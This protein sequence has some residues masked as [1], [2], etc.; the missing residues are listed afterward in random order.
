MKLRVSLCFV[1]LP[2]VLLLG[3]TVGNTPPVDDS[4]AGGGDASMNLEGGNPAGDQG[5][6]QG[7]GPGP[8]DAAARDAGAVD[9]PV[10]RPDAEVVTCKSAGDCAGYVCDLVSGA[11]RTS[12]TADLH[13]DYYHGYR[14][15]PGGACVMPSSCGSDA[16]CGGYDCVNGNCRVSCDHSSHCD[17]SGGYACDPS[18]ACVKAPDCKN[19]DDCKGYTCDTQAGTCNLTCSGWGGANS[20]P[21]AKE[22]ICSGGE[23]LKSTVCQT[24]SECSGY[25]CA[26]G[27]CRLTCSRDDHCDMAGDYR[28][29]PSGACVKALDCKKDEDCKGFVCERGTCRLTC[30]WQSHCAADYVCGPDQTCVKTTSCKDDTDCSGYACLNGTCAAFCGATYSPG[31]VRAVPC[32]ADTSYRCTADQECVQSAACKKDDECN[33]YACDDGYCALTCFGGGFTNSYGC[34]RGLACVGGV[35]VQ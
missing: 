15:D 2:M 19:D 18:G 21:C 9:G 23:C 32:A 7:D 30:L 6:T 34:P 17:E 25:D 14:C 10:T 13:C 22:Y 33:G 16:D 24:D 5:A 12:C 26:N 31:G 27:I 3:C 4:G 20:I 29:D 11:C 8:G 35:C 1:G 28:C